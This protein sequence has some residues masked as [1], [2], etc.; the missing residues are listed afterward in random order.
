[1]TKK[2]YRAALAKIGLSIVGAGKYF[3]TN[4]RQSQRYAAGDAPIPHLVA[5]NLELLVSG[6][7]TLQDLEPVK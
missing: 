3:G 5:R 7:I 4:G 2:Q 1:M 6:K